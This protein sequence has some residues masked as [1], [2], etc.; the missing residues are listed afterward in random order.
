[1]GLPGVAFGV[2]VVLGVVLAVYQIYTGKKNTAYCHTGDKNY[3]YE[4]TPRA[5]TLPALEGKKKK[6]RNSVPQCVICCES[7]LETDASRILPCKHKFHTQCI[8]QWLEESRSCP[9]CRLVV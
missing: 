8:T 7:F 1:M 4:F 5:E 3:L 6:R 9:V 2:A